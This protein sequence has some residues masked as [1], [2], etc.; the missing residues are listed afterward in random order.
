MHTRMHTHA[1]T[2][3]YLHAHT[4]I[5]TYTHTQ[6]HTY[7]DTRR[8]IHSRMHKHKRAS[9]RPRALRTPTTAALCWSGC[10][11][12]SCPPQKRRETVLSVRWG[13]TCLRLRRVT[14][15]CCVRWRS[16]RLGRASCS[17]CACRVLYF[18]VCMNVC[19]CVCVFVKGAKLAGR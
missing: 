9:R 8:H 14:L 18:C 3:I 2:D 7:T 19:V 13:A 11:A 5:H 10:T 16:S 4:H 17:R 1:D 12:P 15:H 6:T